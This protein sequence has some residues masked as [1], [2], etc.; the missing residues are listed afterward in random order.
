MNFKMQIEIKKKKKAQK[1]MKTPSWYQRH[2]KE[3]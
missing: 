1:D 2:R 3:A